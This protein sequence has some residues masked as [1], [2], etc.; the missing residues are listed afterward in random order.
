MHFPSKIILHYNLAPFCLFSV[1]AQAIA[2]HAILGGR[3]GCKYCFEECFDVVD[4]EFLLGGCWGR[5]ISVRILWFSE[6]EWIV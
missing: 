2:R 1:Y 6:D 4:F 5:G 3:R